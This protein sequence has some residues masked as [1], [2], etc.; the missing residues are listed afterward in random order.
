M[1]MSQNESNSHKNGDMIYIVSYEGNY[2]GTIRFPMNGLDLKLTNHIT[3][4][5][6]N[7]LPLW[8]L[9]VRPWKV[10]ETQEERI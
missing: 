10:T 2:E 7:P 6:D 8:N 1:K 3:I 5:K 4:G 9:T